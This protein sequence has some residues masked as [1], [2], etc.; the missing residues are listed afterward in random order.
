ME[1]KKNG[2]KVEVIDK[3]KKGFKK[4][5]Q[6]TSIPESVLLYVLP[7]LQEAIGLLAMNEKQSL[8]ADCANFY[9]EQ[10]YTLNKA[11]LTHF[12]AYEIEA[13]IDIASNQHYDFQISFDDIKKGTNY[14]AGFFPRAQWL[15]LSSHIGDNLIIPTGNKSRRNFSIAFTDSLLF[16]MEGEKFSPSPVHSAPERS[17]W[18]IAWAR[19]MPYASFAP[20]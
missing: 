5:Y 11:T 20:L 8:V 2:F 7:P 15:K 19:S 17:R 9:L 13:L 12:L 3:G 6:D 1:G 10:P 16:S 18:A 4:G 14:L